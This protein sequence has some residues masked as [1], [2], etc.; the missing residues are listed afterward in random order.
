MNNLIIALSGASHSGKTTFMETMKKK[1]PDNVILLNEEIRSLDIGNID[2][3]RKNPHDY[4]ELEFKII[5]AKIDSEMNSR[6]K[7]NNKVILIDRSLV[8]SYFYYTFYVDKSNLSADDQKQ[9][10]LFLDKLFDSMKWHC[11]YIYDMIYFLAP[12]V[13]LTRKDNY[14]QQF[15]KYTQ[16]NEF[17]MMHTLTYGVIDNKRKIEEFNVLCDSGKMEEIIWNFIDRGE[18]P[19]WIL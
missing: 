17:N 8:D 9:Y 7:Y 10:H 19:K 4:L 3:I 16:K 12:I 1:Y 5:Q 2:E 15:L 11:N 13:D 18:K 14:T 6:N